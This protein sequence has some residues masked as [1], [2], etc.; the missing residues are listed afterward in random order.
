[1]G[2]PKKQATYEHSDSNIQGEI[3]AVIRQSGAANSELSNKNDQYHQ[4]YS[5]QG[6]SNVTDVTAADRV[7]NNKS[8]PTAKSQRK[9][10]QFYYKL[11]NLNDKIQLFTQLFYN[12]APKY[13][14]VMREK[15]LRQKL[16]AQH[17]EKLRQ[18]R[19]KEKEGAF[20][21]TAQQQQILLLETLKM[22]NANA[23][24]SVERNKKKKIRTL[25]QLTL[26]VG[27]QGSALN[28]RVSFNDED[29][30]VIDIKFNPSQSNQDEAHQNENIEEETNY[31]EKKQS[32]DLFQTLKSK[33]LARSK[34]NQSSHKDLLSISPR[35]RIQQLLRTSRKIQ[36]KPGSEEEASPRYQERQQDNSVSPKTSLS[37]LKKSMLPF[38]TGRFKHSHHISNNPSISQAKEL[39]GGQSPSRKNLYF[40]HT[41]T[42]DQDNGTFFS[43]LNPPKFITS[44]NL[45]A[46]YHSQTATFANRVSF[47]FSKEHQHIQD[48]SSQLSALAPSSTMQRVKI[49]DLLKQEKQADPL[50]LRRN[51]TSLNHKLANT[52]HLDSIDESQRKHFVQVAA[53]SSRD[54][55]G[56]R[57]Q[58]SLGRQRNLRLAIDFSD[59]T[60]KQ[61]RQESTL[62]E[63]NVLD[64]INENGAKSKSQENIGQLRRRRSKRKQMKLSSAGQDGEV[65]VDTQES[66]KPDD[67]ANSDLVKIKSTIGIFENTQP[68]LQ[69]SDQQQ[70]SQSPEF[71]TTQN[72]GIINIVRTSQIGDDEQKSLEKGEEGRKKKKRKKSRKTREK[73]VESQ[74]FDGQI[75]RAC[76]LYKQQ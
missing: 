16:I 10:T 59:S 66:L 73:T 5:L 12:K 8:T 64:S 13:E 25:Q 6:Q 15:M 19:E 74:T 33:R 29:S 7:A 20:S 56:L 50:S 75:K 30:S 53:K 72:D 63:T 46:M 42:D 26:P 36:E 31:L 40:Q 55:T 45:N 43:S 47:Q 69:A 51:F 4:T 2:N 41:M 62:E 68:S 52:Q 57:Q 24:G 49:S 60:P 67:D 22:V 28:K 18:L 54:T 3:S 61:K 48:S 38:V 76:D 27:N 17:Q 39:V 32:K 65:V 34:E 35:S 37:Q 21:S 70:A 11:K 1:M 44:R 14:Q 58:R 9:L 23:G 71:A